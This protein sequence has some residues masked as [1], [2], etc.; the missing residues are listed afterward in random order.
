M[1]APLGCF[2]GGYRLFADTGCCGCVSLVALNLLPVGRWID[3]A[4]CV[5][6]YDFNLSGVNEFHHG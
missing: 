2:A 3:P 1:V 5:A 6:R 4:Y